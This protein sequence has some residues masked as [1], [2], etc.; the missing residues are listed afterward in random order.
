MSLRRMLPY[1]LLNVVVSAVVVL[2]ILWW[3]DGRQP[4]S[5]ATNNALAQTAVELPADGAVSDAAGATPNAAQPTAAPAGETAA[6]SDDPPVHV[7]Q[8]GD[9]LGAIS[10]RYNVSI[11]EIIAA[12]S[13]ENPNFLTVGQQ[14]LIPVGGAAPSPTEETAVAAADGE[15]AVE[16]AVE[17]PAPE[18]L[19][20]V[21][22][23]EPAIQI[24]AVEGVGQV[25]E[26]AVQI[27]NAGSCESSM[28][29]WSVASPSGNLYT[30]GQVTLYGEGAGI[31][32]HTAVGEDS[33]TD[34]FWGKEQ[35]VWQSG[36][37]VQLYDESGTLQAEYQVP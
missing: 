21:C 18:P 22:E 7:V 9:T 1:I 31:R 5:T 14:L 32:V 8:L 28:Q 27:V 19:T 13:I 17:A 37:V 29:G 34:L 23:G 12:N 25:G 10:Q 3:W 30:F 24:A 36:S 35:A 26:E 2:T 33:A 4:E 6:D 20:E 11:D 15:E 16:T